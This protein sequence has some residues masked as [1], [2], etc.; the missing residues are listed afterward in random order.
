MKICSFLGSI[1]TESELRIPD[2]HISA[3]HSRS[4]CFGKCSEKYASIKLMLTYI[5]IRLSLKLKITVRVVLNQYAVIFSRKLMKCFSLFFRVCK[6]TWILEVRNCIDKLCGSLLQLFF[7]LLH[8]H[9]VTL[10]R[11]GRKLRSVLTEGLNS[12]KICRFFQ[13]YCIILVDKNLTDH[14]QCLLRS[15]RNYYLFRV[16][17]HLLSFM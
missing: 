11:D 10:Q 13:D 4:Y 17:I 5:S 7:Q 14:I 1:Y 6:S 16:N 9:S 12:S 15:G 3:S 8:I 2:D